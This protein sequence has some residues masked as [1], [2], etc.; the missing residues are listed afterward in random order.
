MLIRPL[1]YSR[2]NGEYVQYKQS[3]RNMERVGISK[4]VLTLWFAKTCILSIDPYENTACAAF[5]QQ[6]NL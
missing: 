5:E 1:T 2:V 4:R 3:V 6:V